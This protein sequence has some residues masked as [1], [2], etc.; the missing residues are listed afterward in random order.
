MNTTEVPDESSYDGWIGNPKVVFFP[1]LAFMIISCCACFGT[2]GYWWYKVFFETWCSVRNGDKSCEP[3]GCWKEKWCWRCCRW[4]PVLILFYVSAMIFVAY[5]AQYRE[6]E[7][8]DYYGFM[9][10]QNV[11]YQFEKTAK[12]DTD[13]DLRHYERYYKARYTVNWP[14][15]DPVCT[16]YV[17]DCSFLVCEHGESPCT[18]SEKSEARAKAEDCAQSVGDVVLAYGNTDVCE[19]SLSIPEERALWA[20][21]TASLIVL[22]ITLCTALLCWWIPRCIHQPTKEVERSIDRGRLGLQGDQATV[23]ENYLADNTNSQGQTAR[24]E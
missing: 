12:R 24:Q 11:E 16:G 14:E 1:S 5:S 21:R 9:E 7:G 13:G 8:Y 18:D 20:L 4:W 19:A 3:C 6:R 17:N 15:D 10:I 23:G 2:M 22:G